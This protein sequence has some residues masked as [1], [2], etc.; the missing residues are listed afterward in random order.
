MAVYDPPQ[1]LWKRNV[2]GILDFLLALF[3]FGYVLNLIFGHQPNPPVINASVE[4]LTAI[5]GVDEETAQQMIEVA[6]KHE[7]VEETEPE[8]DEEEQEY[9]ASDDEQPEEEESEAEAPQEEAKVE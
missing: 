4:D 5:E 8:G 9:Q 3:V 7:Q 2:A 6:R 1:P